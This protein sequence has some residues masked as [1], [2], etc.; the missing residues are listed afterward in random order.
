MFGYRSCRQQ[1]AQD[2][3]HVMSDTGLQL[4]LGPMRVPFLLLAVVCV[5]L[6]AA[7]AHY[8]VGGLDLLYLLLALVGGLAAHIAVNALN[9]YDDFRSGLDLKTERTPF[10]GGSGMLPSYPAGQR[11]VL[12]TSLTALAVM[13]GVGLFFI[14]RHGWDLLPLGLAGVLIITTYTPLMTRS[15]LLCLVVPGLGFGVLMVCGTH[16]VLGGGWSMTA[17]V[18]SLVPTFLVCNLLL[19]NQFPDLAADA[20]VGR[21]HLIIVHGIRAGVRTYGLFLILTYLTVIVGVILDILP[22]WSLL[23]LLTIPLAVQ[24]QL[25]LNRYAEDIPRLVPFLG[26]NVL[27]VLLTPALTAVGMFVG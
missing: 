7:T 17:L 6:G 13:A 16:F 14:L 24:I 23:G 2:G 27:L 5:L 19:I 11:L 8:Q 10:S 4:I 12:G 1:F 15:A 22:V 26:R 18:A 9:E 20:A 25:G 3:E 21:R